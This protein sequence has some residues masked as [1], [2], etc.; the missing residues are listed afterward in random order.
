MLKK[1]IYLDNNAT[2][3]LD[4]RVI[5][6][7]MAELND[8]PS[9]PSSIHSFGR[10]AKAKLSASRKRIADY[11]RVSPQSILFTSGGTEGLNFLIRGMVDENAHI[12]TSNTEHSSVEKTLSHLENR[13]VSITYLPSGLRGAIQP[14]QLEEAILPETSLIVLG[15]VNGETG[16]KIDLKSIAKVAHKHQIPLIIDAVAWIGKEPIVIPEGVTAM[17]CSAHKF[18]GPHGVG[19]VFLS[20]EKAIEPLIR[21]GYQENS[22]RAGT[23]NLP[24]I[25][26]LSKAIELLDTEL[27]A[28]TFRMKSLRERFENGLFQQ[29]S[30]IYINGD[31]PRVVNTVNVAFMGVEGEVLL[32]LLD[33]AGIAV[34]HGSACSSGSL[35]PSR[36]LLSM[37][38]PRKR[39]NGS[40]RFSLSRFTKEE[41][42][43][44]CLETLSALVKK[45]R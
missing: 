41:E 30:D 31:G 9:N 17:A 14:E 32:L 45:L 24:G 21:G 12:I 3:C 13:G 37:G 23:E 20:T 40:L 43:D 7:M 4:P 19:F 5:E 2:T 22:L 18:H 11:L 26:G 28:A 29:L 36:V 1:R 42:I 6:A 25:I 35:Q 8:L 16:V 10:E 33:Q 27:E 34:S 39:A 38:I 44:T 15:A